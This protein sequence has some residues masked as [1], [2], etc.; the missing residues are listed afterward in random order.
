[1]KTNSNYGGSTRFAKLSVVAGLG[2][3]Q[4][5]VSQS[6]ADSA[7]S[8]LNGKLGASYGRFD[9]T[10]DD[11]TAVDGS[12][13]WPLADAWGLQ[14]DGMYAH[15]TP[16]TF[17]FARPESVDYGGFGGHVFWRDPSRA[18]VGVESTYVFS[19]SDDVT[20]YQIGM[21]CEYYL[22]WLTL[23]IQ[24]GYSEVDDDRMG[25]ADDGFYARLAAGC[26]PVNNLLVNAIFETRY[27]NVSYGLE[28][29]YE[30]PVNGL[31][32]F[33]SAMNGEHGDDS[34]FAGMRYYFGGESNLKNRHRNSDPPSRLPALFAGIR[35]FQAD[36]MDRGFRT[37]PDPGSSSTTG[38]TMNVNSGSSFGGSGSV[39]QVGG[40]TLTLGGTLGPG[41]SLSTPLT[42]GGSGSVNI[43]QGST[44][45]GTG[46]TQVPSTSQ[47]TTLLPGSLTIS[48]G[49]LLG[50]TGTIGQ[51]GGGTLT[52]GSTIGS[53]GIYTI[54]SGGL[55]I[56]NSYQGSATIGTGSILVPSTP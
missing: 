32:V 33:A 12:I 7:V 2:L 49:S 50:S 41:N 36:L 53:G 44:T 26:Y 46:N 11:V 38:G 51:V 42:I 34:V 23:G 18:M 52:L 9:V 29:E 1:M 20:A 15:G 21:E 47:G 31:S 48:T 27:E 56:L 14:L 5:P 25:A 37:T 16:A 28:L 45:I 55:I 30:T 3:A 8:S 54:T 10:M 13:A 24:A 39:G 6:W 19:G 4:L 17:G 43:Q 35:S 22:N 40:G